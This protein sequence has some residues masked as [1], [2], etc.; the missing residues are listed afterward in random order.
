MEMKISFPEGQKVNAS[1]NGFVV[2]TDQ[3]VENGGKGDAPDPFSLFLSSIGTCT[4]IY[5]LRFC[6]KRN[7][8]KESVTIVLKTQTNDSTGFVEK[9]SVIIHTTDQFPLKYKAA[10]L[11]TASLCT[12]KKHLESPPSVELSFSD[13]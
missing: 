10:L 7:I 1:F 6:Q 3:S 12:V 13:E 2:K 8:P 9:I 4:G 11:K 5:V